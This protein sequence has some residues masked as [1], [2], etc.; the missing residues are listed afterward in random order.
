M[1]DVW[2]TV[3]Q[4]ERDKATGNDPESLRRERDVARDALT[5]KMRQYDTD[6]RAMQEAL[7]REIL[8]SARLREALFGPAAIVSIRRQSRATN[9][10]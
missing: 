1:S 2:G 3:Y 4:L 7:N 5:A 8:E 10:I 6:M 9:S